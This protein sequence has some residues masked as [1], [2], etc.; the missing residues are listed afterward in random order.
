M[1]QHKSNKSERRSTRQGAR[2]AV[3]LAAGLLAA[4][5]PGVVA[6]GQVTDVGKTTQDALELQRSGS[7]SVETRPILKDVASRT[8]DRYL[9]SFTYP[10]PEKFEREEDFIS[11]N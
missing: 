5:L 7:K 1:T 3:F 9:E 8:Y 4:G 2:P 10:I 6:A 11:G